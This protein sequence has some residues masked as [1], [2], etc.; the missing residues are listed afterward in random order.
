MSEPTRTS[1]ELIDFLIKRGHKLDF[2]DKDKIR[3]LVWNCTTQSY[4]EGNNSNG[5][6]CGQPSC[7]YCN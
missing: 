7:G 5:C 1:E 2:N 4:A 3:E 6:D